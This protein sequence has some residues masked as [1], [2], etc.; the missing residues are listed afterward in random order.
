MTLFVPHKIKKFL[1]LHESVDAFC[2]RKGLNKL[3]AVFLAKNS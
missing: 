3:A 1:F 2:V